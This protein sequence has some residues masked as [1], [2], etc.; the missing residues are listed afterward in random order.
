MTHK[1]IF[2][3]VLFFG[4]TANAQIPKEQ[5]TVDLN[6]FPQEKVE[7]SINSEL[8]LAGELLQYKGFVL[9][10]LNKSS[11]L[12]KVLYVSMRNDEDSIVFSHKLK[13]EKGTAN[14]DFFIPSSLKTGIYTL[15]GY[16]NFSRNN[17]QT[18]FVQKKLYIINT[19]VKPQVNSKLVD[20]VNIKALSD[21]DIATLPKM[22]S[23]GIVHIATNKKTYG[24][25]EQVTLNIENPSGS[26]DGN[27]VLSVRKVDPIEISDKPSTLKEDSSS[28]EFYVPELRGELIS[29]VVLSKS[30]GK[31]IANKAVSLSIPGKDYIFKIAKT[32]KEGRFFFSVDEGYDADESI[33][34]L[35]KAETE[36]VN[37]TLTMDKKDFNLQKKT[38]TVLKLDPSIKDW[39]EER[40]VQLQIENAYFDAKK[41]SILDNKVNKAFYDNLGVE[42]LL[43]DYTRFPSV[44]ETFVEVVT[45]AAVR[46]SGDNIRFLVYNAYDP[47][48]L[49]KFNDLPPLV[50]MDGMMV[51]NNNDVI[52]YNSREIKGIRV[53]PQPYRYGPKVYSGIIAIETKT[54]NFVP[55][56]TEDYIEKI[57]L[58]P[59]VK[60]KQSYRLDYDEDSGLS[61]IPDYR[62]QLLWQPHLRLHEKSYSTT[63]YTSDVSGFYE[64]LFQGYTDDGQY[65][66]TQKYITV[67]E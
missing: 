12:S 66:S 10:K 24:H 2:I 58:P 15:I 7:L 45:P 22:N 27:F 19:F 4:F 41:D 43:D 26:F 8:L 63:F 17:T 36:A 55:R 52:N 44:R 49:A 3:L 31:P 62:F 18:G 28:E 46:G 20:T 13:V 56:Q 42:F 38:P 67:N 5:I 53:V 14:G 32:N 59:A 33:V 48:Q 57:K 23:S 39:L 50:L 34:Q 6:V 65:I 25:R 9:D 47:N 40:S 51:Q 54:G 60:K 11:E 35:Y 16:T 61:R 30:D 21:N 37:F 64:V 29:G 1:I